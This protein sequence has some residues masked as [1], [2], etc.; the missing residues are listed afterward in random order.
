M[1]GKTGADD[2]C[3]RVAEVL[4]DRQKSF[5]GENSHI[6]SLFLC[7]PAFSSRS[8][9]RW[10]FPCH[11]FDRQGEEIPGAIA[12]RGVGE[13]RLSVT[14]SLGEA[15]IFPIFSIPAAIFRVQV[16]FPTPPF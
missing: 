5:V 15:D 9:R 12:L 16:V 1:I 13:D 3:I 11:D 2:Q 7:L 8:G 10:L 6:L 14:G 4:N